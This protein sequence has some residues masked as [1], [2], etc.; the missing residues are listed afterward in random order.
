[1]PKGLNLQSVKCRNRTSVLYLLNEH[2]KLSRKEL[3]KRLSLTP[4]GVTKICAEL[5]ADGYICEQGFE[6]T[7]GKSGRKEILLALKTEDKYAFC[8]NAERGAITYALASLDGKLVCCKTEKF[9]NDVEKVIENCKSFLSDCAEYKDK[10]IGAGVCIIGDVQD[11]FGVW[12]IDGLQ[13]KFES[14]LNLPVTIDNNV[15]AFAESELIFGDIKNNKSVIFF[16]WGYGVGSSIVVNGKVFSGNDSGVTE[17]GHYI[18]NPN[19]ERCRCG[20]RGC[21]ETEVSVDAILKEIG[22]ERLSADTLATSNDENVQQIVGEKAKIV[23]LALTNTATILNAN[24]I[25]LFGTMFAN[26]STV[27]MLKKQCDEFGCRAENMKVSTLND[28]RSFIGAVAIC[29][30]KFFFER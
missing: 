7:E 18:V 19:G 12:K 30:K 25:V 5:I 28:R 10:I 16:K 15:K 20:R 8:V 24:E 1:M 4:A 27:E 13:E 26:Q 2:K 6:E 14:A 9:E 11:R 3:S 29:A 23:A 17:I 21:L 22:D